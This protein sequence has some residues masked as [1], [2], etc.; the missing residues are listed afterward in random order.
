MCVTTHSLSLLS[1]QGQ[2][3]V[4]GGEDEEKHKRRNLSNDNSG[5]EK[6]SL[7]PL[8]VATFLKD[9]LIEE[10]LTSS[11]FE[12][13]QVSPSHALPLHC[14]LNPYREKKAHRYTM[15]NT[16]KHFRTLFVVVYTIYIYMIVQD[17]N[18]VPEEQLKIVDQTPHCIL[19]FSQNFDTTVA[20]MQ[21]IAT[22]RLP[23]AEVR[24]D[25]KAIL[26][27]PP[28]QYTNTILIY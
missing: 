4:G 22:I 16:Y 12:C 13:F 15:Q 11:V 19:W 7:G 5:N 9:F 3:C 14:K 10:Y 1:V 27:N 28:Q 21:M 6:A 25:V 2:S 20:K 24:L 18:P 26:L 23:Q 8:G 17:E